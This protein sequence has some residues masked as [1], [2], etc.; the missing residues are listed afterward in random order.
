MSYEHTLE[1]ME[2]VEVDRRDRRQKDVLQ[3]A[4]WAFGGIDG[5]D[6]CK[7]DERLRRFLEEAGE[8]CQALGMEREDA[9]KVITGPF[10][11]LTS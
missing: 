9:H 3:W 4:H 5:F 2:D 8:L 6:P 1:E 10:K 11:R 7:I